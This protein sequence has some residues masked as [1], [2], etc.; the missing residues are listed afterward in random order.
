MFKKKDKKG[1][2]IEVLLN[3]VVDILLIIL[4]KDKVKI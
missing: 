1:A 2:I 3:A 4:T